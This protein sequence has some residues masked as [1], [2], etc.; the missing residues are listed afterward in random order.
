MATGEDHYVRSKK[1]T[2]MRRSKFKYK[3]RSSSLSP[4]KLLPLLNL[5]SDKILENML[6]RQLLHILRMSIYRSYFKKPPLHLMQSARVFIKGSRITMRVMHPGA[7]HQDQGVRRHLMT[8]LK[9]AGPI[10]VGEKGGRMI[11]R[12]APNSNLL[13]N[14]WVHPGMRGK[15]FMAK[16]DEQAAKL[17][18]KEMAPLISKKLLLIL[19]GQK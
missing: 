5:S 1:V 18:R 12:Q 16:A 14:Q 19:K 7:K 3:K 4:N 17:L 13:S 2:I 6:R 9:G 8:Y 10:P 15:N 11:F